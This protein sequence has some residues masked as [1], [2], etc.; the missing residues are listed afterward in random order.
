MCGF[1]GKFSNDKINQDD[2]FQANK[3]TICR[4][5][6]QLNTMKVVRGTVFIH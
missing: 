3:H 5:P 6:D 1:I 4:G 2:I